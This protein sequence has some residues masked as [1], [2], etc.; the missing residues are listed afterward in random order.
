VIG[1]QVLQ[2]GTSVGANFHEAH[3]ASSDVE[4]VCKLG[5]CPK[6]LE[7]TCYWLG[8][9]VDAEIV[10]PDRLAVLQ[11]ECNQLSDDNESVFMPPA[12]YGFSTKFAWVSDRFG[13]SWQLNPR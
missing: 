12:N 3:R 4:F 6:E 8:R 11:D 1:K 10:P 5:D 2:S 9:L 7:E 13:V